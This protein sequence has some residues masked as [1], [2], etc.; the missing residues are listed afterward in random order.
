M[1]LVLSFCL[2]LFFIQILPS[3]AVP[4]STLGAVIPQGSPDPGSLALDAGN[5]TTNGTPTIVPELGESHTV[6]VENSE[7]TMVMDIQLGDQ[8]ERDPTNDTIKF[9]KQKSLARPPRDQVPWGEAWKCKVSAMWY[10]FLPP[11]LCLI[12]R[13]IQKK[14]RRGDL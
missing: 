5:V 13:W 6:V 2:A 1:S 9:A 11:F 4:A 12:S 10:C 7:M 3:S 8:L 14:L